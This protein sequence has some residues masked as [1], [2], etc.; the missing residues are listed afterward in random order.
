LEP[1][2]VDIQ[3][4]GQ[5]GHTDHPF[6]WDVSNVGLA[7]EWEHV[8]FTAAIPFH[9]FQNDHFITGPILKHFE[10][11]L[12][13]LFVAGKKFL[14]TTN[15]PVRSIAEPLP[16]RVLADAFEEFSDTILGRHLL[17]PS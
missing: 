14:V 4:T 15:Y 5:F 11:V 7:E 3:D 17:P 16:I 12:W 9:I 13:L 2:A 8:M 10:N 1:A 6:V